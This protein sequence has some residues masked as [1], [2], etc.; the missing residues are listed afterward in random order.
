MSTGDIRARLAHLEH[1][2]DL[3]DTIA[4]AIPSIVCVVDKNGRIERLNAA[5]RRVTGY[6]GDDVRGRYFWEVF[7]PWQER[8]EARRV[9]M[10]TLDN[11]DGTPVEGEWLTRD[12]SCLVSWS[13]AAFAS[14]R[15]DGYVICGMDVTDRRRQEDELRAS[16]ARV[17]EAADAERRRIER[18]LHDGAQQRLV[19]LAL[20]LRV[21]EASAPDEER[22][23]VFSRLGAELADAL[24]ELRELAR[25]IHPAVLTTHGLE[26]ALASLA[27]R[28]SIPVELDVQ[29]GRLPDHVEAVAYYVVAE[30]LA[31]VGKYAEATSA[32][33]LVAHVDGAI[34]VEVAD[35]GVG[36]ADARNGSGL[37]G[38]ADRVEALSGRLVVESRKGKGT[39]VRAEIPLAAT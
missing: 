1:E 17:V 13:C 32:R 35:D 29:T 31:N 14:G 9:I 8:G 38:L 7:I 26:P 24:A 37:R 30:A 36:G 33:V 18:N 3:L 5:C 21:A 11:P 27:R 16:R 23:E 12:G 34:V 4:D 19:S 10:E 25:G 6:S 28:S 39:T 2:V 20:A 22:K 15:D